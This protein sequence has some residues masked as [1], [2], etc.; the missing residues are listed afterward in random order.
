[1]EVSASTRNAFHGFV[2]CKR[3]YGNTRR[4]S[5]GYLFRLCSCKP[6]ICGLKSTIFEHLYTLCNQRPRRSVSSGGKRMRRPVVFF[7]TASSLSSSFN[8][9]RREHDKQ[10]EKGRKA[11]RK[12]MKDAG[13]RDPANQLQRTL[14]LGSA[15]EMAGVLDV[16]AK[17]AL[18][19]FGPYCPRH[20]NGHYHGL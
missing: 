1:M 20:W 13:G 15:P 11:V 8:P 19:L 9:F 3:L 2:F 12:N 18:S 17:S 10:E 6:V 5:T 4:R 16:G 7:L 14:G